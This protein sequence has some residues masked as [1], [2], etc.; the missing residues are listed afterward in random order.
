TTPFWK[1][2]LLP[3]IFTAINEQIKNATDNL[4]KNSLQVYG[5]LVTQSV[6][7]SKTVH[8]TVFEFTPCKGLTLG[9]FRRLRTANK[10]SAFGNRQLF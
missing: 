8:W 6:P 1:I 5:T 10:G 9:V 2:S 7:S 3:S 4:H